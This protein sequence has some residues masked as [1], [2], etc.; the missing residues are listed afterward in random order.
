MISGPTAGSFKHVAHMGYDAEKGFTSTNVDPT[1]TNFIQQLEG[2]GVARELIEQNM[3]FI[4]DFV[5]DAQKN[6][7]A[8]PPAKKKAPP[9][10][11]PPRA[12][13]APGAP[14]APRAPPPRR[15]LPAP[16][17]PRPRG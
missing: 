1:W 5:R 11:A 10:P 12:H 16:A 6:A 2:Q 3:D 7:P 14:A 8:P 9:P 15:A 4:K 13:F 17:H